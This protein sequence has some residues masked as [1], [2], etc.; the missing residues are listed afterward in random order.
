VVDCKAHETEYVSPTGGVQNRAVLDIRVFVLHKIVFCINKMHFSTNRNCV[1]SFKATC[2]SR[3]SQ[4]PNE[5]D[6]PGNLLLF[7]VLV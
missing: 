1:S 7:V 3:F 2:Q 4:V 5:S 6:F